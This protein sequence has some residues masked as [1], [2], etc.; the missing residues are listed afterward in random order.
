MQLSSADA[1]LLVLALTIP[2]T[3]TATTLGN[4][5]AIDLACGNT[6]AVS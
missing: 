3:A 6:V 5:T 2:A 1:H 4:P